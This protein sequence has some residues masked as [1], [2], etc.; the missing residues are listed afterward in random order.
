MA[1]HSTSLR[2][3]PITVADFE[4]MNEAGVFAKDEYRTEL[5]DGEL[6]SLSTPGDPHAGCVNRL[7]RVFTAAYGDRCI[8]SVQNPLQLDDLTLVLPDASLLLPVASFYDDRKPTGGDALLVVEVADT[9]LRD[10]LAVKAPRYGRA[11][12]PETWVIDVN[13]RLVHRFR[14]P[15]ATG[16]AEADTL[17]MHEELPL[18]D[19]VVPIRVRDLVG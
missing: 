19:L 16:Y 11:G 6:F 12:V 8:V 13:G 9:T 17:L 3:R 15:V 14:R 5:I 18:P 4:L 2:A 1:L 10:D 7:I